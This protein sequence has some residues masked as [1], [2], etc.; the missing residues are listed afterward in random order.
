MFHSARL[1]LTVIYLIIIMLI[2]GFFSIVIYK[3]LTH[4][5]D[6]KLEFIEFRMRG[7]QELP[8]S[9]PLPVSPLFIR[10]NLEAA[11]EK[12]LV[13]ILY[14]NGLIWVVFSGFGYYF[15]GK[16]LKP[17]EGSLEEQK[18]FVADASHELRTPLTALK[19]SIEVALRDKKMNAGEAREVLKSGLE[20]VDHLESLTSDLLSL[21][22]HQKTDNFLI[23]QVSVGEAIKNACKKVDSIAKHKQINITK[24]IGNS[25]DIIVRADKLSL[26]KAIVILLDNAIKYTPKGGMVDIAA[27]QD[28]KYLFLTVKDTG[29]GIADKDIEHIFE[30]FYRV[31]QSRSKI[32]G[33]GLGLALLKQIVDQHKGLVEVSSSLSKGSVFTIKIPV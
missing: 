32:I 7:A 5:I 30:R 23:E 16:T 9:P 17:I 4:E 31:D 11:K 19:T 26:E 25:Q 1:K 22:Q 8:F 13:F 10:A 27:K 18:R 14:A 15:A 24:S 2:S 28:K 6:K 12:A 21:A 33:F 20:D 3:G 29:I